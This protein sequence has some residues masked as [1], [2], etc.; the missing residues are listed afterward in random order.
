MAHRSISQAERDAFDAPLPEVDEPPPPGRA[1]PSELWAQ[2]GGGMRTGAPPRR[3]TVVGGALAVLVLAAVGWWLVRPAA[4]PVE[5][6]LPVAGTGGSTSVS[7]GGPA[8]AEAAGVPGG[9]TL[10]GGS[11]STVPAQVVV[12]AAGAVERPGVYRLEPGA[13]VDDLIRE[14]GGLSPAADRDRVNLAAPL[15]DGERVWVPARGQT[16][17]P[18]V[19]AG[20]GGGGSGS[21]PSGAGT[22]GG[23]SEGGVPSPASP[24]DL[25]TATA[26]QLDALPGVGPATAA[27]ILAYRSQVGRFGAV[28]DLLEVRGI[29]DAKLEQLRPL[30]RV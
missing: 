27:A 10:V 26:D 29:G 24:V 14:A 16:E 3:S 1:H 7:A 21:G 13:R 20:G 12:Q 2:L 4:A 22:G 28:D 9:S 8:G 11:S 19:V 15:V 5:S 25:N 17:V 23:S 6:T 18:D 30:V